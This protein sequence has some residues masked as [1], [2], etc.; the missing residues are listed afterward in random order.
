MAWQSEVGSGTNRATGYHDY[1]TKL[2][3]MITSQHVAT[4]AINAA[5][6]GY[7]VGDVLTLTH[8]GAVLDAKFEVTTVGGSGDI[9]GL[10]INCSGAFSNRVA[11]VAVN[12]G[13]TGYSVGEVLEILGGSG[14]VKAKAQVDT[15]AAGVI[16]AV[17]LFENGGAYATAPTLTAA[18][19]R[20]VGPSTFAGNDDATLDLT[21]TTLVGTTGLSVTGGTG[22]SA[23]VDITLAE[24]GWAVDDDSSNSANTNNHSYNSVT[25][26]KIVRLVGDATGFTN[27]PYVFLLSGTETVGLD[28]RYFLAVV[29]GLSHNPSNDVDGQT[30]RSPGF[31]S[32]AFGD[33]GCYLLFP[34]NDAND[35]DFWISVDEFRVY[36]QINEN[37]SA[38][39][40]DGRYQGMHFGFMD[41]MG[42]ETEDPYPYLVFASAKD[43]DANPATTSVDTITSIAELRYSGSAGDRGVCYY[44]RTE[45]ADWT[46]VQNNDAGAA[47]RVTDAMFPFGRINTVQSASGEDD[48]ITQY[49]DFGFNN[50]VIK[51]DRTA[52][53]RVMSQVPGS[54]D[55]YWLVPLVVVRGPSDAVSGADLVSEFPRGTVRG[56][57]WIYND[58]GAGS[59]L[60]NFSEDYATI[61]GERYRIFHNHGETDRYQYIAVKEDT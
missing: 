20:G 53:T 18:T 29:G 24:S 21:M 39:T 35:F 48:K 32:G 11:T 12:A 31:A 8:A 9:T 59:A 34:Q 17:S 2:V 56:V 61:S 44:Y 42:T 36:T 40:D 4:V 38:N 5:G 23:T 22:S 33:D 46:N 14:R 52:S 26:E 27:K 41:R 43:R 3:D 28:T 47:G 1:L 49:G 7:V 57:F 60:T 45:A 58:D 6:T 19:T 25:N 55:E 30:G 13:G 16:T 50:D 10:R 54:T 15:V 37:P 51:R